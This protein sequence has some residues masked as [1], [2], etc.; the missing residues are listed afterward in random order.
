M[1]AAAE[2]VT[3]RRV[4]VVDAPRREGD[5]AVLV[6]DP[7]RAARDLGWRASDRSRLDAVVADA[8]A[9][10]GGAR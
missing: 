3:G 6:A 10:L 8:W 2:R 4:P 5:P 7:A 1:I 9:F